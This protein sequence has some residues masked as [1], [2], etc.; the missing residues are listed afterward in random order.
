VTE[1]V[2][3]VAVASKEQSSGVEEINKAIVQMEQVTQQNA[4]LVEEVTAATLSFEEEA[5]RLAA[6]V[7]RFTSAESSGEN[8]AIAV[9]PDGGARGLKPSGPR[10]A[11]KAVSALP[12]R[13][14]DEGRSGRRHEGAA[15][16]ET[17]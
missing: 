4:A 17:R 13:L 6:A 16:R 3:E 15:P 2:G 14:A 9:R 1:L 12:G 11:Q 5:K 10:L 8:A 7:S